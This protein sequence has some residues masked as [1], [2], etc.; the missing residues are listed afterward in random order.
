M[1]MH[2]IHIQ[3]DYPILH[4][5]ILY[6]MKVQHVHDNYYIILLDFKIMVVVV[7]LLFN[8]LSI[9]IVQVNIHKDGLWKHGI[10]IL[11]YSSLKSI[12]KNIYYVYIYGILV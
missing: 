3:M 8:L 12:N 10:S 2:H 6:Q 5:H 7:L 11:Y 9:M 4:Q 1:F